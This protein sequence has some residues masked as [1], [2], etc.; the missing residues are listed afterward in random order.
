MDAADR[1]ELQR[2]VM[3]GRGAVGV[4]SGCGFLCCCS[5]DG[6]HSLMPV[7]QCN[8]T[9]DIKRGEGFRIATSLVPS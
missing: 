3:G 9:G 1:L 5:S 4:S 6:D 8:Y 2:V 7:P